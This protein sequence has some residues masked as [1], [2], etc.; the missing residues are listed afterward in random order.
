MVHRAVTVI[1]HQKTHLHFTNNFKPCPSLPPPCTYTQPEKAPDT[2]ENIAIRVDSQHDVLHG[3]VVDEWALWVDEENIWHPDLLHQPGVKRS[4]QV[5][6]RGEGQPF[7]LPVVPQI[8]G[9]SKV[10][11]ANSDAHFC[12]ERFTYRHWT[13]LFLTRKTMRAFTMLTSEMLSKLSTWT[14]IPTGIAEP[15]KQIRDQRDQ[16]GVYGA[17]KT[18]EEEQKTRRYSNSDET[19]CQYNCINTILYAS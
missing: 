1:L 13:E 5:V 6:S 19:Q 17:E 11:K 12:R 2:V 4:T 18:P 16:N 7:V 8:E 14:S 3:G 9:H 10:L 15:T